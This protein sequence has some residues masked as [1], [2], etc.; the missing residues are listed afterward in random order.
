MQSHVIT[1]SS[2]GLSQQGGSSG[3]AHLTPTLLG[4]GGG[5][6]PETLA[7]IGWH[8]GHTYGTLMAQAN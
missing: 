2:G 4:V 3:V 8:R 6:I 7:V 5:A 1:S